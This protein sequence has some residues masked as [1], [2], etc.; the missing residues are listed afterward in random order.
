MRIHTLA[1]IG[2]AALLPGCA[3]TIPP[4]EATRFHLGQPIAPGPVRVEAP[5][6]LEGAAY[7]AAVARALARL[8]FADAPAGAQPAYTAKVDFE[9]LSR[10]QAR[11]SPVSIGIGGGSFGRS[12]G[13]G[14]GTSFGIGGGSREIVVTR[15]SVQLARTDGGTAVWEGRAQTQASVNAPAAQ[16]GLAAEKLADALFSDFPGESGRTITVP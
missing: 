16:P 4:V 7:T 10:E 8:G 12:V 14:I 1:I 13:V 11:R 5:A 15:L 2:I 3:A 9:R 6:G